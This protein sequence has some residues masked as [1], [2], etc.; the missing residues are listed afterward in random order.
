MLG[1]TKKD[2]VCLPSG[3]NT[4]LY[5]ISM[6]AVPV[7]QMILKALL[8]IQMQRFHLRVYFIC[9]L[10]LNKVM[11]QLFQRWVWIFS[12]MSIDSIS[13]YYQPLLTFSLT[14][15]SASAASLQDLCPRRGATTPAMQFIAILCNATPATPLSKPSSSTWADAIWR[16]LLQSPYTN[17][18][19]PAVSSCVQ[20]P[21]SQ[22]LSRPP[23]AVFAVLVYLAIK[24]WVASVIAR[25]LPH[26]NMPKSSQLLAAQIS[27]QNG[28]NRSI[29]RD[30][31]FHD[32]DNK[33]KARLKWLQLQ[34][35]A[36]HSLLKVPGP[37][38]NSRQ[39]R[40]R[41]A[42]QQ[43]ALQFQDVH[44]I[45]SRHLLDIKYI[46]HAC[47]LARNCRKPAWPAIQTRTLTWKC[48]WNQ[49]WAAKLQPVTAQIESASFLYLP[50]RTW[51]SF[52][53]PKTKPLTTHCQQ[54][55]LQCAAI[56]YDNR[57]NISIGPQVLGRGNQSVFIHFHEMF[58]P[59]A[60]IC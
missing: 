56:A 30:L 51:R 4:A 55:L 34:S 45:L 50:I 9:F 27:D 52:G 35:H 38:P 57:L 11:F 40:L 22:W 29:D 23:V 53:K 10:A 14:H 31:G 21:N 8:L 7:Q 44:S 1:Y 37:L 32:S 15:Q 59:C 18:L 41:L 20:L 28:Q 5:V 39:T 54:K 43:A 58:H 3:V 60:T 16:P 12:I 49:G 26:T 36:C 13:W 48:P 46:E 33:R 19:C 47:L 17:V 2:H 25:I 42:L 24:T 6:P